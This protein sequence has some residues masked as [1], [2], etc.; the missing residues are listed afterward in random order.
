MLQR[1]TGGAPPERTKS[2]I[3][4]MR[5]DSLPSAFESSLSVPLEKLCGPTLCV[6][7]AAYQSSPRAGVRVGADDTC[8][9]SPS[10]TCWRLAGVTMENAGGSATRES[11][12]DWP[13]RRLNDTT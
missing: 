2:R 10:V 8:T 9:V 4:S 6:Q 3:L 13:S 1:V 5:T 7:S 12:A 11:G